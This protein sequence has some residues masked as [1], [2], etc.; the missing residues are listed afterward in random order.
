MPGVA[1]ESARAGRGSSASVAY[2]L[3]R[4]LELGT[5]HSRF[6]SDRNLPTNADDNHIYDQAVTARVDLTSY[7]NVK[8]EGHFIDGYGSPYSAHG[9]YPTQNMTGFQPRTN[10][11]VLRTGVNF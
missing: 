2:R 1:P 10:M 7:W 5:Y 11:L 3:S 4:H 8:V 6:I 9:F